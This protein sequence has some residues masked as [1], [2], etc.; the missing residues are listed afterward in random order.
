MTAQFDYDRHGFEGYPG[1]VGLTLLWADRDPVRYRTTQ[2]M[3][4]GIRV[5][6]GV[7]FQPGLLRILLQQTLALQ[8][9]AYPLADQLN[10]VFQLTLVRRPDA[11]KPG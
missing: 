10:Q 11:L 5:V 6:C 3:G 1:N 7:E 2:E 8:A 9:T 4:H